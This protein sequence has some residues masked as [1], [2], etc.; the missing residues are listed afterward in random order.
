MAVYGKGTHQACALPVAQAF[1][2]AVSRCSP[3]RFPVCIGDGKVRKTAGRSAPRQR[4]GFQISHCETF[5]KCLHI[6]MLQNP[7]S[8]L[9][10]DSVLTSQHLFHFSLT[11]EVRPTVAC[12][13]FQVSEALANTF[14]F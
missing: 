3:A 4:A 8:R 7:K 6:R 2:C 14:R 1:E 11:T 10:L 12:A 9:W 5:D 13:N